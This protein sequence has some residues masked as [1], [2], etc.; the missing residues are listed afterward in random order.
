[1]QE[2]DVVSLKALT[3][4]VMANY[5]DFEALGDIIDVKGKKSNPDTYAKIIH[6]L[7]LEKDIKTLMDNLNS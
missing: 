2:T 7:P 1:M 4:L 3:C 5:D 6:I